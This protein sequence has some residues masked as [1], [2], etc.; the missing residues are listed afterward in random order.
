MAYDEHKHASPSCITA[1]VLV[2][3]DSRTVASDESGKLICQMLE[4]NC[5]Q[6][7]SFKLLKNDAAS[8]REAFSS[9]LSIPELKMV[10]A[11]GGTGLSQRDI[12]VETITPLLDKKLDGFGELFRRLSYE[13]IRTGSIMSRAVA[14][15]IDG[16]VVIC[17][18]G[19]LKAVKLAMEKIILPEIGHLVREASR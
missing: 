10:I 9:L 19:S 5:H 1:G 12:T 14:G 8:I 18:P 7:A 11:S 4:E 2:I 17:L 15:T 3:S 6:L 13:E 16:K